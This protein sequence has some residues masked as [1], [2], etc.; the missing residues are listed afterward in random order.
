MQSS[1][2]D[3]EGYWSSELKSLGIYAK[4]ESNNKEMKDLVENAKQV[5]LQEYHAAYDHE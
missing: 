5:L 2:L 3:S 1:E 4:N